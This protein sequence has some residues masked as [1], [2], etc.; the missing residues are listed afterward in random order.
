MTYCSAALQ[1]SIM[2]VKI[3]MTIRSLSATSVKNKRSYK[4]YTPAETV[5]WFPQDQTMKYAIS[6]VENISF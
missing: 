6:Y 3:E 1:R 4:D 5:K 2:H